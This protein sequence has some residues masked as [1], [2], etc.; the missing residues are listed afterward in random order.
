MPRYLK[1]YEVL[2]FLSFLLLYYAV[3]VP[4]QR[5]TDG[6]DERPATG[7]WPVLASSNTRVRVTPAEILLYIWIAGFAYDECTYTRNRRDLLLIVVLSW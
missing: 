6:L 1:A 4:V 3:L 2:F 5:K 7:E